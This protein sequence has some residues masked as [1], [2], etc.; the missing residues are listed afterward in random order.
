LEAYIVAA[1]VALGRLDVARTHLQILDSYGEGGSWADADTSLS[2]FRHR[3]EAA[4]E[5]RSRIRRLRDAD[6]ALADNGV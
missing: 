3:V 6:V 5:I 4:E 1:S 2:R